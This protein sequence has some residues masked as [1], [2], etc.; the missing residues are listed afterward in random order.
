MSGASIAGG[1]AGAITGFIASGGNPI[2]AVIGFSIGFALGG[3]MDP[4]VPL[5]AP[6]ITDKK[7]TTSA[8]GDTIGLVY[9]PECRI[10]GSVIWATD[11]IETEQEADDGKGGGGG[12]GGSTYTYRMS[13]ALTISGRKSQQ[14]RRCW[15]NGKLIFDIAKA[16]VVPPLSQTSG[17]T[18]TKANKTH[19]VFSELHYWPGSTVQIPDPWIE[20]NEGAGTVPAYRGLT[21]IVLK[22]LQL[23]DFGNRMPNLEFELVADTEISVGG[24]IHDITNRCG[25]GPVSVAH[26][27]NTLR[28]YPIGR[29]VSG[30][31]AL[32]PLAMAYGFDIAES[33]GQI[34]C[35]KRGRSMAGTI[36]EDQ[37]GAHDAGDDNI[38]PAIF[39]IRSS[40]GLPK[41]ATVTYS[42]PELDYQQGTQRAFRD[43]GDTEANS[44]T[45]LPLILSADEARSIADRMLWS[46]WMARRTAKASVTDLW[47]KRGPGQVVGVP[48]LGQVLP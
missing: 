2:G 42:D 21:Y 43:K 4:G 34:R 39:D 32:A 45:D 33:T 19:S 22:D 18:F 28:G 12:G 14:V 36:P 15:A 10:S 31:G 6:R 7:I 41:Q 8:Y 35:V 17:Q 48:V 24:V 30:A 37:M 29:N 1:V 44:D 26:L 13:L 38:D 47:V 20:A 9:G 3:I 46:P 27:H 25:L 16:P 11:L 23:A 40:V 5:E